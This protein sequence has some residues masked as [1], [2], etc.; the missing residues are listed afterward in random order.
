MKCYNSHCLS[1]HIYHFISKNIMMNSYRIIYWAHAVLLMSIPLTSC[2]VEHVIFTPKEEGK[3]KIYFVHKKIMPVRFIFFFFFFP[4]LHLLVM[5]FNAIYV[6]LKAHF[7]V[8]RSCCCCF[9]C[10]CEIMGEYLNCIKIIKPICRSYKFFCL[11]CYYFYD[12]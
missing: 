4:M 6:G 8:G 2:F 1:G 11:H 10:Q 9:F 3:K 7:Q 12:N 5:T